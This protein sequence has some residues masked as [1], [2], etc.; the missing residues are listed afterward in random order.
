MHAT[1]KNWLEYFERTRWKTIILKQF[2]KEMGFGFSHHLSAIKIHQSSQN[3]MQV[4]LGKYYVWNVFSLH[5]TIFHFTWKFHELIKPK[6]SLSYG[7]VF[8]GLKEKMVF[9]LKSKACTKTSSLQ[10]E[11]ILLMNIFFYLQ[12]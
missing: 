12:F 8:K 5:L 4:L 6:S 2:H 10:M 1:C 3:L 11:G 9:S 7:F